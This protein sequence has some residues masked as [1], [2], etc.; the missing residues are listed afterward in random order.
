MDWTHRIRLRNLSVLLSLAHTQ[1]IS[2]SAEA[3]HMTQPGLSKWLK[4]LE[5]D[6]GLPLFERHARGL[7]LT[8]YGDTLIAHVRRIDSHLSAARDEMA[9]MVEGGSG[10]LRIGTSG[11]AAADTVPLAVLRLMERMPQVRVHLIES[12]MDRLIDQL[13]EGE[14]DIIVGR[15]SADLHD[16]TIRA[17][18][19]Y[20][21]PIHFVCRPKH[22]VLAKKSVDWG[23]LMAYPWVIWP[24]GTP[25][26][27]AFEEAVKA[28]RQTIP[29]GSLESNSATMNLTL[30]NNSN[31]IGIA[32]HRAALRFSSMRVMAIVPLRLS[33]Y[34]SVAM[35]SRHD[36]SGRAAVAA[37]LA[38]I[39]EVV[40]NFESAQGVAK[41]R[42]G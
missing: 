7:R 23:A 19:L 3:L 25:I 11:A 34:G 39:R 38:A 21:E 4:E 20:T 17:E 41:A 2:R 28:A 12:T 33:G 16:T 6:V 18:S 31:M 13:S 15:A 24:K 40:V 27:A 29:V 14:L 5:D 30:L 26:R 1:N 22:P 42:K 37:G 32:S 8:P 36:A 9:S 10:L 35:Y